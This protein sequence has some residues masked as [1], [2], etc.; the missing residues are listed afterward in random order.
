M[1]CKDLRNKVAKVRSNEEGK[2]RQKIDII[3]NI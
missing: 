2:E 1:S 3:K